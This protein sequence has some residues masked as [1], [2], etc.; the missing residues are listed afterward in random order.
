VKLA[1]SSEEIIPAREEEDGG[2]TSL[3][4]GEDRLKTKSKG[5]KPL[6]IVYSIYR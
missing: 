5:S 4:D 2:A 3:N 1:R 6:G